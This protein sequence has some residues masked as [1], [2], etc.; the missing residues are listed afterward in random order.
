M[1]ARQ[2]G[3]QP[4]CAGFG[5]RVSCLFL[6]WLFPSTN[7][8]VCTPVYRKSHLRTQPPAAPHAPLLTCILYPSCKPQ[9]LAAGGPPPLP[10]LTWLLPSITCCSLH[11]CEFH[12]CLL[13][14]APPLCRW[15]AHALP[16]WPLAHVA[17]KPF[18]TRFDVT[19]ELPA[20]FIL[21]FHVV[22]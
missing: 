22:I 8:I 13:A 3:L 16:H 14:E 10:L 15:L 19:P 11:T 1:L 7:T 4:P 2:N 17:G 20:Q 18:S 12:C 6:N 21:S 5:R 9:T